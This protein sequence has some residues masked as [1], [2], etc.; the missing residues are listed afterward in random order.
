MK[1]FEAEVIQLASVKPPNICVTSAVAPVIPLR[2]EPSLSGWARLGLLQ[3]S[4]PGPACTEQCDGP[5][6]FQMGKSRAQH[7]H[8]MTLRIP[9][10]R[11]MAR[12]G[13]TA[14]RDGGL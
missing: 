10:F 11:R 12:D 13:R 8:S 4:D 1:P 2:D 6:G 3:G 7:G 5:C 9:Q 14:G